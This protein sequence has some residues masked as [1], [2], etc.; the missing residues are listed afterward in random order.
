MAQQLG[1][2]VRDPPDELAELTVAEVR[3]LLAIALPLPLQ[4]TSF[5]LAWS[6]WRRLK[7]QQARCSHY[8]RRE[9]TY[10]GLNEDYVTKPP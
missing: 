8:R 2:W 4:S 6:R 7:R 9:A 1:A 3:R 5:R 10:Q